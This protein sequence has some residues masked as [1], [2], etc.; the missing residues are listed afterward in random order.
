MRRGEEEYLVAM[1]DRGSSY[2]QSA[3]STGGGGFYP[4]NPTGSRSLHS[5]PAVVLEN[6]S[7]RTTSRLPV[8]TRLRRCS[9][10]E[11]LLDTRKINKEQIGR[12]SSL[13]ETKSD[14]S[15]NGK[16]TRRRPSSASSAERR[17]QHSPT[18]PITLGKSVNSKIPLLS[19]ANSVRKATVPKTGTSPTTPTDRLRQ[20]LLRT[21]SSDA[22]LK[23]QPLGL[24]TT[25]DVVSRRVLA[26]AASSVDNVGLPARGR[27]VRV[28]SV[29]DESCG[30]RTDANVR[31]P[32]SSSHVIRTGNYSGMMN[33]FDR[34]EGRSRRTDVHAVGSRGHR[35]PGRTDLVG[36]HPS[37]HDSVENRMNSYSETALYD[38]HDTLRKA[39][40][41]RMSG[42]SGIQTVSSEPSVSVKHSS[43]RRSLWQTNSVST[44]S[45]VFSSLDDGDSILWKD[46][47]ALPESNSTHSK[48]PPPLLRRS[49]RSLTSRTSFCEATEDLEQLISQIMGENVDDLTKNQG[50]N[51]RQ[52]RTPYSRDNSVSSHH[53]IK[54]KSHGKLLNRK[55]T[56]ADLHQPGYNA[57]REVE[58]NT[59]EPLT[60]VTSF[61]IDEKVNASTKAEELKSPSVTPSMSTLAASRLPRLQKSSYFKLKAVNAIREIQSVDVSPSVEQK[62]TDGN[63]LV[64]ME[65]EEQR[66]MMQELRQL[67]TMLLKL[68]RQLMSNKV[69]CLLVIN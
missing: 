52:A 37:C 55:P 43:C 12:R 56:A 66:R 13:G 24:C 11:S 49:S 48:Y 63:E 4:R 5:S 32:A 68:K 1:R 26:K 42:D 36:R 30:T 31:T 58:I 6:Q 14:E 20:R 57:S 50:S 34:S 35:S 53:V 9:S 29:S 23:N 25:M 10:S 51:S 33:E 2:R 69:R 40:K 15:S 65:A 19:S 39:S 41:T 47:Y 60:P 45:S 3:Q 8:P 59:N 62:S 61:D 46:D 38:N 18:R 67:K 22:S 44:E 21:P 28:A 17:G 27:A 64:L 16:R 7:L 54:Q